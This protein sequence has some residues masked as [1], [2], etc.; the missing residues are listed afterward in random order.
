MFGP[1]KGFRLSLG[2]SSLRSS[3][4]CPIPAS[5]DLDLSAMG[6]E[7]RE[8]RSGSCLCSVRKALYSSLLPFICIIISP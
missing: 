1:L 3:A 4:V 6:G 5:G 7:S 8:K 2:T